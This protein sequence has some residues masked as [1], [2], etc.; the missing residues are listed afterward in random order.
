MA[1]AVTADVVARYEGTLTTEQQTWVGTLLDDASALL[2]AKIPSLADRAASD[3]AVAELA[4]IVVVSS[5]LRTVRNPTGARTTTQS[6]GPFSTYVS[7]DTGSD[8][9]FTDNELGLLAA[10]QP[11]PVQSVKMTIPSWRVP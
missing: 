11:A 9:W 1:Y 6:A 3:T 10:P 8:V 5:V 7:R 2:D 4:K